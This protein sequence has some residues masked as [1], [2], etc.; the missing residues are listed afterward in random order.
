MAED[1]S[2][3]VAIVT[4]GASGIGAAIVRDL[5]DRGAKVIVADYNLAGAEEVASEAGG[6]AK[7][8]KVD[9]SAADEVEAMVSYAVQAFGRL[10]LAVNNA[11]IGGKSAPIGDTELSEWHRV[12]DVNLHGVFYGLRYEIP[13]MLKTGGGSIVNMASILGAVGWRG[14]A[15]YVAAKHAVAGLTKTAALEYATQGVRVNAVGPAFIA[16]PLIEN[17]MDDEAR[18]ALVGLHPIGRLGTSEE[19][20]ALT[21]FLLS[22]AASFMTGAYY[23]VDGGYLAQ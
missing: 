12:I 14:S 7:A 6:G 17:S 2:G 16:T 21:N 9:T 11:G 20:A 19:V 15:G 13:A 22:D 10:D 4:G 8:F 5:A 1:F 18:K 3:K 23:P